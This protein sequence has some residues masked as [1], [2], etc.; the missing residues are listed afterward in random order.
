VKAVAWLGLA[1]G[2]ALV[3][4][5]VHRGWSTYGHLLQ[6]FAGWALM[7][8]AGGVLTGA[9]LAGAGMAAIGGLAGTAIYW[10]G[11]HRPERE[12][13]HKARPA[14]GSTDRRRIALVLLWTLLAEGVIVTWLAV[15]IE[16][17]PAWVYA[18]LVI[19]C[20]LAGA[21]LLLVRGLPR[22]SR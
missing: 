15:V 21:L 20:V 22:P 13:T 19:F 16:A 3:A 7:G 6:V 1:L 2:V 9:P 4:W 8:A 12:E 18:G 5:R 10:A 14:S 11:A 17:P